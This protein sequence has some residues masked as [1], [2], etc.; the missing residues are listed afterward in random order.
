[1]L[2]FNHTC[3]G[4]SHLASGKPCQDASFAGTIGDLHLAIVSDGH[5]GH[6]HPRSA[7]GAQFAVETAQKIITTQIRDLTNPDYRLGIFD[8]LVTQWKLKVLKHFSENP[9]TPAEEESLSLVI[10][11]IDSMGDFIFPLY[12]CTLMAACVHPDGW[13]TFQIGDGICVALRHNTQSP[14][15]QPVPYDEKCFLYMTSSICDDNAVEEFRYAEG[16]KNSTP[17]AFFLGSDGIDNSF[18]VEAAWHNFYMDIIKLCSSR[19]KL[20][21]EL[22]DSLPKLS[23]KGSHDDISIAAIV[24]PSA[25]PTAV[26]EIYQFQI[27]QCIELKA[28]QEQLLQEVEDDMVPLQTKLRCFPDDQFLQRDMAHLQVCFNQY[29][30][31]LARVTRRLARLQQDFTSWSLNTKQ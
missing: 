17:Y 19:D 28:M 5:G 29:Q 23:E 14:A 6:P 30:D 11:E 26:P 25:L 20:M 12:G 8:T 16:D 24:N 2:T 13:F 27:N 22:Q 7:I 4:S 31:A 1:M 18:G 21:L 15:Y 9:L 10:R 3:I